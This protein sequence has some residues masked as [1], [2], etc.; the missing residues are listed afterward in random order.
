[1]TPI[2]RIQVPRAA[3]RI[4][5]ALDVSSPIRAMEI[6]EECSPF[7][8]GFKIGMQL[9]T[10]SG[11]NF[12]STL[13]AKGVR[14]FLDLKYHDIPNT[15][16]KAAVEATKLGVWMFNLHAAGGSE[17]MRRAAGESAEAAEKVGTERPK[18]IAVTVLTSSDQEMLNEIGIGSNLA[19][20]VI[21]LAKLTKQSGL[22][23]VVAS[24]HEAGLIRSEIV[25]EFLIV[26]PGIRPSNATNN[27]QKRVSSPAFAFDAGATHL[28]IGRP[29]TGA[30]D[31][32]AELNRILEEI[33]SS[34]Q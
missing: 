30:N 28:V 33:E 19:E 32:A 24:A 31:R 22:D 5:I 15:V 9:F 1:M 16:A 25:D 21:R 2:Q 20:Q 13:A 11:P 6:V 10:S 4:F 14:V 8:V 7:N 23:G 27:D 12:V 17:M 34:R 18:V 29:V 3:E 26:T